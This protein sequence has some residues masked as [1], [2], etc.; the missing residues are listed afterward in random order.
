MRVWERYGGAAGGMQR[1]EGS[2]FL[3]DRTKVDELREFSVLFCLIEYIP[4]FAQ[5]G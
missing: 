1:Q 4:T 2:L 5:L 3:Q